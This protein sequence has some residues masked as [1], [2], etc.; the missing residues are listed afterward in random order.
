MSALRFFLD[1]FAKKL[2]DFHYTAMH[3]GIVLRI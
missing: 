3:S 1:N 2:E